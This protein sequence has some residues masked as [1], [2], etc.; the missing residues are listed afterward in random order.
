VL[1]EVGEELLQQHQRE[2][3]EHRAE[4][5]PHPAQN[6]HHERVAR[7]V[8]AE[9]LGVD[10]AELR[11][12]EIAGERSEGAGD[13]EARQLVA[14]DRVAEGA[15]AALVDPDP[16]DDL[17]EERGE[18]DAQ[19]EVGRDQQREHEPVEAPRVLEVD[20][21]RV[22]LQVYVDAVGAAEEPRLRDEGVEHLREGE[23][24]HDEVDAA[25]AQDE[26]ADDERRE[27][28]DRDRRRQAQPERR[29]LVL[30]REQPERVGAEAEIGGV[31]EADEAGVADEEVEAHGEDRHDHDLGDELEVEGAADEGE[32]RER[33]DRAEEEPAHQLPR[34]KRPAGRQSSTAA[35]RR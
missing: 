30:G 28:A 23:R 35:M 24:R 22:G 12:G 8:P 3:A 14:E 29:G 18:H 11:R 7:A 31:A 16:D 27:G 34:P 9:E 15:H 10:E 6:H 2:G 19:E 32:E 25:R 21:H 26:D 17:A 33:H 1:G 13:D 5:A 4:E 20:E